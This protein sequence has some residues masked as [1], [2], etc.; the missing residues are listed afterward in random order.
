MREVDQY[1]AQFLHVLCVLAFDL[2]LWCSVLQSSQSAVHALLHRQTLMKL[3]DGASSGMI[4]CRWV[5]S[6]MLALCQLQ[7]F[8]TSM[9]AAL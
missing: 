2:W 3:E 4:L 1:V 8:K 6:P 7:S 9:I 5:W